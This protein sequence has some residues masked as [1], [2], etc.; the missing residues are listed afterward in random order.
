MVFIKYLAFVNLPSSSCFLVALQCVHVNSNPQD[1]LFHKPK[2]GHI[3]LC[4][5]CVSAGLQTAVTAA[6][7]SPRDS[8]SLSVCVC[9]CVFVH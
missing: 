5:N 7:F 2:K 1:S 9:L 3:R 6:S 8:A 4:F